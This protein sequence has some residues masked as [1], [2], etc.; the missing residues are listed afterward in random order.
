[1]F[2]SGS[3][4]GIINASGSEAQLDKLSGDASLQGG[5]FGEFRETADLNVPLIRNK[6]ALYLAQE[7]T[8]EGFQREPSSDLTRRQYAAITIDPFNNHKTKI[9]G[10]VEF[11]NN[12]ENDENQITPYDYVTPWI[13]AG[14]PVMNPLTDTIT[15]LST[16]KT[17]GPYVNSTTSPNYVPGEPTGTGQLTSLTS[18]LFAP[19]I[20][21]TS[22]HFT[23]FYSNGQFLYSFQPDQTLGSPNGGLTPAQT[24]SVY[25]PAGQIVRQ[26]EL[27]NSTNLPIPGVGTPGFPGGFASYEQPGVSDPNIYNWNNGPNTEANNFDVQNARTFHF[28]LQQEILPNL[29][30]DLA[31]FRQEFHDLEVQPMNQ[32]NPTAL[33]IDTNSYLLNG[34]PNPYVGSSF[35]F[36]TLGS[37]WERAETNANW[38]AMLEYNL[39]LASKVPDW[40]KWLGHHRFMAEASTHDDVQLQWR[41]QTV[42]NGGDGSYTSNLYQ[43]NT[44]P[45]IPGNYYIGGA[46]NP[47]YWQYTSA[48]GSYAVTKAPSAAGLPGF[49]G[50]I[51]QNISVNTY[52][53]TTGQWVNSG[54]T[55]T[56]VQTYINNP[57]A[58]DIQDQKTYFWQSFFWN[59]RIIGSFGMNDDIVK[60][61]TA[62]TPPNAIINGVAVVTSNNPGLVEY[63]NGVVIPSYKYDETPWNPVTVNNVLTSEGELGGNT[64]S[65]GFVIKPFQNWAAI[66]EAA[67]NGNVVAGFARTLGFTFNKSD[68][69]NPPAAA[70]TDLFGNPLPKPTGNEKDYGLEIATPDKKLFLRMTW[71]RSNNQN[72]TVGVS[73]TVTGRV[74]NIDEALISWA[75][76]IVELRNGQDPTSNNF[77]NLT[78]NPLSSTEINQ[79]QALAGVPY[80]YGLNVSPTGG[81][82]DVQATN[83]TTAGGYDLELTYN[84]LPNWTM[85]LTG[86]RQ[87]SKL[88][89]VDSQ[90]QAYLAKRMPY[91]TSVAAPDYPNPITNYLGGGPSSILY[92]GSF[93]A[94]YSGSNA[95]NGPGGT[96]TT[97]QITQENNVLIPLA[98]ELASQGTD[99]PGERQHS[100]NYL[101]NYNFTE[102]YLKN[103]GIGGAARWSS[104]AIQG[105]YGA[106]A[107]ALLNASGQVAASNLAEP[108]YTPAELHIDAWISYSFKFPWD[109]GKI[110][111]K[112]QLNV[113][114]LTSNGYLLPIQYNLDGTPAT[115]RI[116]PPRQFAL[117]TS[118]HF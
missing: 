85:K 47:Q 41:F 55:Q 105:Y 61:R 118:F 110:R 71:F 23:E 20:T 91:W 92:V 107:P 100:F 19:G 81:Y 98:V 57:Y 10:S 109:D 7:F 30:F 12:Y 46:T 35:L 31:Y 75:Q 68:N 43:Q 38:R 104:A 90:A 29:N 14:K 25:T 112:V 103:I 24:P 108:I 89:A 27:T 114:D 63:S 39:D 32:H 83:T 21:Y 96:P 52:N 82:A 36:D 44:N 49:G 1:M 13:A 93:W 94:S 26:S 16:G 74:P 78:I 15:Y 117:T 2:G 53:Y 76:E 73:E 50:Q 54:I 22:N 111:A 116:I 101:T 102:G 51:P 72:N 69:F 80:N 87:D 59:D 64:Y 11:W 9:T 70:Y 17:E 3:A 113:Q 106:T 33:D 77:N 34:Q 4:A 95:N 88:S 45:A 97:V 5:S 60:N 115:Y 28:D 40:L 18:P 56:A 48:P 67:N 99:V 42:L 66:D 58:E 8:S 6:V 62:A 37:P 65:E 84:P 86:G 79:I